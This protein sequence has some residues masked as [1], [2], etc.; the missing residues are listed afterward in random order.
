MIYDHFIGI[1]RTLIKKNAVVSRNHVFSSEELTG[2]VESLTERLRNLGI[3]RQHR[4]GILLGNT[5]LFIGGIETSRQ[6]G[7]IQH[8]F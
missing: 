5:P 3:T 7:T 4:I 8:P 1:A 2:E 6:C